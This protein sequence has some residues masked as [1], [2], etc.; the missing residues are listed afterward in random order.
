M[1]YS[2]ST[3]ISPKYYNKV[4]K[5]K[6]IINVYIILFQAENTTLSPVGLPKL[7]Q[8]QNP[9][10]FTVDL[11]EAAPK[12]EV[13]TVIVSRDIKPVAFLFRFEVV[14][15]SDVFFEWIVSTS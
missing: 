3:R 11:S 9:G 14:N 8:G 2:M 13:G 12:P 7:F 5:W 10:E 1:P 4:C 6:T 15:S